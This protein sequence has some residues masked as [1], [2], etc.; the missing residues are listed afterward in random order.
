MAVG[1]VV[2]ISHYAAGRGVRCTLDSA[3]RG[4]VNEVQCW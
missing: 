1:L 4:D 2:G 3:L